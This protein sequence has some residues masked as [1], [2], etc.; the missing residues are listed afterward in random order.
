MGKNFCEGGKIDQ[1]DYFQGEEGVLYGPGVP[2][3]C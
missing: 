3:Y 1:Q 2:D